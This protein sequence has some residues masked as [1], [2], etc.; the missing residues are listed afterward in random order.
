MQEEIIVFLCYSFAV[1]S[2]SWTAG[3]VL[4]SLLRRAMWVAVALF[5]LA[6]VILVVTVR[7]PLLWSFNAVFSLVP[8]IFGMRQ[9]ARVGIPAFR[10]AILIAMGTAVVIALA[11]WTSGWR[12]AGLEAWS[13]G[14]IKGGVSW[15]TRLLPF[16]TITWPAWYMLVSAGWRRSSARSG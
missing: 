4:G 12:Q 14:A 15:P 5:S 9:G 13:E 11:M 6:W 8:L 2:C 10:T 1:I 16:I 7:V 3:V